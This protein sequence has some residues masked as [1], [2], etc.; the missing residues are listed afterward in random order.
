MDD[1]LEKYPKTEMY[2]I[3]DTI[4]VPH[5]YMIMPGHIGVAADDFFGRIGKEAILA[6]EKKGIYCGI[7]KGNLKYE[8]HETALLVAVKWDGKLND[9]PGLKEYLL[10]C[11]PLCE[12]DKFAGFAFIK[13][14]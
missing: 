12:S 9:A 8:Q 1:R 5:P 4:G 2:R 6:A 13:E 14:E 11:K 3:K 10:E 7:C